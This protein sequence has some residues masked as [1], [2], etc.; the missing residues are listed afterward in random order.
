MKLSSEVYLFQIVDR[1][2]NLKWCLGS[3]LIM[4]LCVCDE[5]L[6]IIFSDEF[7]HTAILSDDFLCNFINHA[8]FPMPFYVPSK[9]LLNKSK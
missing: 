6:H 4:E 9:E 1:I 5:F 7:L 2:E 8:I 3:Y